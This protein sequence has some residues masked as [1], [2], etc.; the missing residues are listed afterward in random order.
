MV[1]SRQHSD[2]CQREPAL[3]LQEI[4]S[5]RQRVLP[6]Q[7]GISGSKRCTRRFVRKGVVSG[8]Q[9]FLMARVASDQVDYRFDFIKP[10]LEILMNFLPLL[11]YKKFSN[12]HL[13]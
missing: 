5:R 12:A 6:H 7:R 1:I 3:R 10:L 4:T 2:V 8:A 11:L 9:E 13:K